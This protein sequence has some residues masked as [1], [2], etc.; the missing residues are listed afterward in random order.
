METLSS[1]QGISAVRGSA[2]EQIEE[3]MTALI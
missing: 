2:Q 3:S 1:L